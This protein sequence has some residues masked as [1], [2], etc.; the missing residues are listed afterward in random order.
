MS[1][2]RAKSHGGSSV[3]KAA[4]HENV[5]PFRKPQ[6][7]CWKRSLDDYVVADQAVL[8]FESEQDA[9]CGVSLLWEDELQGCPF[10]FNPAGA[11]VIPLDAVPFFERAT[12]KFS[13][14]QVES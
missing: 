1:K 3:G 9:R 14:H 2:K 5:A 6:K 10:T 4:K 13:L 7:H 8:T 11:I 12:L